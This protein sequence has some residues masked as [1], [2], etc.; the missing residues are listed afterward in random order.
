MS[1]DG[2]FLDNCDEEMLEMIKAMSASIL[3]VSHAHNNP[4]FRS[5][6]VFV[7][8]HVDEDY[9]LVCKLN[10]NITIRFF[11]GGKLK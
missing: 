1:N 5:G 9:D 6:G 8:E 7:E 3:S 2:G 11:V 4:V 10:Y